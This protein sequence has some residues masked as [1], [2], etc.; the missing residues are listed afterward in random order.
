MEVNYILIYGNPYLQTKYFEK[1]DDISDYLV[2]RRIV[3]Y[4]IFEKMQDDKEIEMIHLNNDV[5]VLENKINNAIKEIKSYD[6]NCFA[7]CEY[8]E[9]ILKILE[10]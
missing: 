2:K 1:F 8:L 6:D 10:N 3:D 9:P 4:K 5:E 7:F